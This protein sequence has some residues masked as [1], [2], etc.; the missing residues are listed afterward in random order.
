M[1]L[2]ASTVKVNNILSTG[3]DQVCPSIKKKEVKHVRFNELVTGYIPCENQNILSSSKETSQPR[4]NF[5]CKLNSKDRV[6]Q[7]PGRNYSIECI[8]RL[9]EDSIHW[10]TNQDG[11]LDLHSSLKGHTLNYHILRKGITLSELLK[12]RQ[13][14]TKNPKAYVG[15]S[16]DCSQ[17]QAFYALHNKFLE[18]ISGY[19]DDKLYLKSLA[20]KTSHLIINLFDEYS[21]DCQSRHQT[22]NLAAYLGYVYA[23]I[24]KIN[25]QK[26]S[27]DRSTFEALTTSLRIQDQEKAYF[28]EL[29][30]KI[31]QKTKDPKADAASEFLKQLETKRPRSKRTFTVAPKD[32]SNAP[33]FKT[34]C[35]Q[36]AKGLW[37]KEESKP[38][39]L[40]SFD[41]K[42]LTMIHSMLTAFLN[43]EE[44]KLFMHC[45]ISLR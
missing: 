15:R 36:Y 28:Y 32:L 3:T 43:L 45:W 41:P 4:I 38:I 39:T 12:N 16:I 14:D 35:E 5:T 30:R 6:S 25:I 19:S 34:L 18:L 20:S 27:L 21:L 2:L 10:P 31:F 26:D 33:E 1:E 7:V 23:H 17:Q 22:P 8:R 44:A 24:K 13:I 29:Q 9:K 11:H 42:S 37:E 40:T